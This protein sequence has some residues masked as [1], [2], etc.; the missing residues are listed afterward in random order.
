MFNIYSQNRV[1]ESA[2]YFFNEGINYSYQNK[3]DLAYKNFIK[4]LEIYEN[5]DMKDSVAECNLKIFSLIDAQSNNPID[6]LLYLTKYNN[7]AIKSNDTVKQIIANAYF[8]SYYFQKDFKKADKFYKK[9][10]EQSKLIK[11]ELFQANFY[12]NLGALQNE[13]DTILDLGNHRKAIEIYEKLKINDKLFSAYLNIAEHF[14][15]KKSYKKAIEYLKKAQTTNTKRY[16]K[17]LSKKLYERLALNYQSNNQYKLAN[18]YFIKL[19]SIKELLNNSK[20][21]IEISRIKEKYDNE[22][23][24]ADNLEIESKIKQNRNLFYGTLAFL[25]LGGTIGLLTLKNARKKRLLAEQQQALEQQKNLTLLK[26]QE[27]N[28]IN[29]MI[30]GQEKE[31]I[32]IAED[33]HDN[34]GSVLATL[35]LHFENLKLNREKKHFNQEE[36]YEKTEKLID[37]TYLKVRNIAHAKNAGVLANKGLLTAVKLMAEKISDANKMT[38]HVHDFGLDKRLENNMEITVFRIIQE[39]VTN[40]IKH[41]EATEATINIALYDHNLNI[42]VEDNGNGFD[43]QEIRLEDGIGLGS[44]EKRIAHLNGNLEIDSTLGKGTTIIMDIPIT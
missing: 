37:E 6:P 23:L 40:I 26:E 13:Y 14:H 7:Y 2:N 8:A 22:K 16:N 34:I 39:L 24:R 38:I 5:K 21:N 15:L 10:L 18:N 9:G 29:A 4:A 3:A 43:P 27:I 31:R 1:E 35:K 32:R 44:I 41:A 11:N 30:D 19:D 17:N 25:I 33:L 12:T 28:T 20:Q 36:L 42:I